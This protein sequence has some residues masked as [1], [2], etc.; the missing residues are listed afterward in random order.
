METIITP[1]RNEHAN[2][3]L[4][5]CKESS[6]AWKY[7]PF[8]EGGKPNLKDTK[9]WT[10]DW[11]YNYSSGLPKGLMFSIWDSRMKSFFGTVGILKSNPSDHVGQLQCCI[12]KSALNQGI[13]TA[14]CRQAVEQALQGSHFS[15]VTAEFKL[16]DEISARL[17]KK[18]GLT[19]GE[20][21]YKD[22]VV[23]GHTYY[24]SEDDP[25]RVVWRKEQTK[26]ENARN[27]L[28]RLIN[29]QS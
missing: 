6:Y 4:E 26:V 19:Y 25:I 1:V 18:I 20:P 2:N 7:W 21:T 23:L 13:A 24:L 9:T 17:V 16:G 11:T 8:K 12:R 22:G 29:S 3:L 10:S 27:S 5:A 28:L 14:A 15:K